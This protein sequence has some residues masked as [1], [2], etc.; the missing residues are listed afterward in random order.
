MFAI[1]RIW[2]IFLR[3]LERVFELIPMLGTIDL[4]ER[5]LEIFESRVPQ[6]ILKLGTHLFSEKMKN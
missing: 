3:I 1:C 2:P 4:A 5:D 6:E